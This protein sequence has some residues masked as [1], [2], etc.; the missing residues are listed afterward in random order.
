MGS[1]ISGGREDDIVVYTEDSVHGSVPHSCFTYSVHRTSTYLFKR[2]TPRS[3]FES[4]SE[5]APPGVLVGRGLAEGV[6][7]VESRVV[8]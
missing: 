4:E 3:P 2:A 5:L 8:V 7:I 6:R 1:R